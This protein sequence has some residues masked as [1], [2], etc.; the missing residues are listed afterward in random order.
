[1]ESV[2]AGLNSSWFRTRY[3]ILKEFEEV[4]KSRGL[5][6]DKSKER[7]IA[8]ILGSLEGAIDAFETDNDQEGLKDAADMALMS[9]I[10]IGK[11]NIIDTFIDVCKKVGMT[12]EEISQ[13]LKETA[14]KS[15]QIDIMVNLYSKAGDR[16]GLIESGNKALG[17]YLEVTDL[18]M[19]SR[20]RLF[21]YVIKA[22]KAADDKESLIQA[23]DKA[24]KDQ[25]EE[26]RLSRD[27]DWILDA[28]KAYEAAEDKDG[29][30]KL[31][32]QYLNLYLREGLDTWLNKAIDVYKKAEVDFVSKLNNLA[33]KLEE[34]GHAEI[35]AI[36]RSK[37][38]SAESV[39]D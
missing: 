17:L 9:Y 15:N 12:D 16:D 20:S 24:L 19:E 31:G 26:K 33:E 14:D 27:K 1:L 7:A 8:S 39:T 18:G 3:A 21:D 5:I 32:N 34:K 4:S 37:A 29:L 28:Q 23:G 22:Y 13:K 10:K 30:T 11:I 25:I 35:S 2:R 38:I 36:L 6:D